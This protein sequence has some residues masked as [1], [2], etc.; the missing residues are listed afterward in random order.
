MVNYHCPRC[1]YNTLIKTK[2]TCHLRRK[3]ICD[4]I[5]TDDT[6][7]E[8][9]KKYNIIDKIKLCENT[10]KIP[11]N[12]DEYTHK[13]LIKYPKNDDEI[14]NDDSDEDNINKCEY[15]KKILSSY[16]NLW[17]HLKT[18]KEKEKDDNNDNMI[19]LVKLLNEQLKEQKKQ[20]NEQMK[21]QKEQI[22][23]EKKQMKEER[24]I[25]NNQI[26][27]QNS[28]IKELIKKAGIT[29]S[30]INIQQNIKLLSY[31]NTDMSHLTDKDYMKCLNH[32]NFCVPYLI[33]QIH[34]DPQKPENHNIYISNIKN[35]YVMLYNGNKWILKDRD[36]AITNL[37]DDKD[38]IL[39][40]KLE[41]WIKK[42][43][44][45]PKIMN[46]FKRYIEKKDNNKVLNKIKDEIKLVLFNNR[47]IVDKK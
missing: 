41:E 36:E 16:K 23:E 9:Y 20:M 14:I 37:I 45:Y 7:I 46:K 17:R 33:E 8:E 10:H 25:L 12:G 40:Q 19:E 42:G 22:K 5:N 15:C 3:Y 6:L 32:S 47:E 2:Y 26:K 18:C 29:N 44:E 34:F 28:Q 24:Q 4:N 38:V 39:E 11:I 13:T 27:E 21:E 30:N 1:G 43:N 31:G 35:N